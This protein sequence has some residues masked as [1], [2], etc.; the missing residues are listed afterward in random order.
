MRRK[1]CVFGCDGIHHIC[2]PIHRFPHPV[3][4]PELFAAWMSVVGDKLP[5]IDHMK[6]YNSKRI[7]DNHFDPTLK[8]GSSRLIWSAI[9]NTNLKCVRLSIAAI[10]D[11]DHN[12][13]RRRREVYLL[14][15]TAFMT[16]TPDPTSESFQTTS[17]PYPKPTAIES[18]IPVPESEESTRDLFSWEKAETIV[19]DDTMMV[20]DFTIAGPDLTLDFGDISM[21]KDEVEQSS[22]NDQTGGE[23]LDYKCNRCGEKITGFRYTCVQCA[24]WD[25]CAACEAHATHDT[26]YVLRVP[27]QRPY[28]EVQA[29]LTAVRQ[30]L[31]CENLLLT[32]LTTSIKEELIDEDAEVPEGASDPEGDPLE[33]WNIS[34]HD[35]DD[36]LE[37]KVEPNEDGHLLQN[38]RG[39]SLDSL[40]STQNLTPRADSSYSSQVTETE[41]DLFNYSEPIKIIDI[42][43]LTRTHEQTEQDFEQNDSDMY[44]DIIQI[45][46]ENDIEMLA[47]RLDDI[48]DTTKSKPNSDMYTDLIQITKENDIEM[49][50][51][52]LDDILDTTKS[53]PNS[54]M[55]TDITQ[56]TK[57]NDT[58]MLADR[59]DDILDTTKSEPQ[60]TEQQKLVNMSSDDDESPLNIFTHTSHI[61]DDDETH[62][63][64]IRT[65]NKE[66]GT[67]TTETGALSEG[68]ET[69][70]QTKTRMPR[71]IIITRS[72]AKT[73]RQ[74]KRRYKILLPPGDQWKQ[75]L[76]TM[77]QSR[78]RTTRK[79]IAVFR[80]EVRTI[81]NNPS[82]NM[83]E[84]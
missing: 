59:L 67:H 7:C 78:V 72:I 18:N 48:L 63:E 84:S 42:D 54:D 29:I 33:A 24:D 32:E 64:Q 16:N 80:R 3:K 74:T 71:N 30:Q 40:S 81:E 31:L 27:G 4:R 37:N 10:V 17:K 12:Y 45:T 43:K 20:S 6:I 39:A 49:L 23:T 11:I 55:Y 66:I 41:N 77:L 57:E 62:N 73:N 82:Y 76:T 69:R 15:P 60:Y 21:Y 70:S 53:K 22:K 75:L 51:D 52:R 50:A 28:K 61:N 13:S 5:Q 38:R 25:L 14:P 34:Q 9:P 68:T 65:Q 8:I 56:I 44:T 19:A 83:H 58:D 2:I 36:T 46:K 79:K 1:F 35:D 47:D 26:H